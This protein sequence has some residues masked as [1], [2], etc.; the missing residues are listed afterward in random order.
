M[1]RRA[2]WLSSQWSEMSHLKIALISGERPILKQFDPAYYDM[3]RRC[4]NPDEERRMA[5]YMADNPPDDLEKIAARPGR[6]STKENLNYNQTRYWKNF[7]EVGSIRL[8]ART[9]VGQQLIS[10][11][12]LDTL[13]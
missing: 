1:V 11:D 6:P 10:C 5:K 8:S 9:P 2:Q 4:F 3:L 12:E 7:P 13:H